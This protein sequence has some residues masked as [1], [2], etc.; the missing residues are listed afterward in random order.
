MNDDSNSIVVETTRRIY[1]DLSDPQTINAA[2]DDGWKEPLWSALQDNGLTLTWIPED[3]GGVGASLADGFDVIRTAGQYADPVALSETLLAG[4]LLARVGREVEANGAM[5]IAPVR[6][7]ETITYDGTSLRGRARAVPYVHDARE[8]IVYAE[9]DGR[10]TIATVNPADCQI[11]ERGSD[12][13]SDRVDVVFDGVRPITISCTPAWLT[14]D[15]YNW[16]GAAIR[17]TQMTG[18]L[19]SILAI[20]TEYAGERVAFGR[21]IAKFQA[22]QHNLA[23]LGG[24]V[25]ASLAASGSA[26]DTVDRES[27]NHEAL[28]LEIASAKI[29]VGEAVNTGAAIAHQ[30]HGAIGYTGEHILQRYTRRMWGWRDDFGSEAEWAVELGNAVA[31]D[32]ADALWPKLTT[33]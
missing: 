14:R 2:A 3:R 19:E 27:N 10:G 24:E 9:H 15:V 26:V 6:Y 22:V 11:S 28:F 8:I 31:R 18:A 5:T 1:R 30:V 17:A 32:G 23:Q 4:W 33:R 12:L 29:R 7:S 16:M 25:A 21:P 13:G 20:S